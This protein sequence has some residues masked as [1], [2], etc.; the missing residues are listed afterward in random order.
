MPYNYR[1]AFC[2]IYIACAGEVAYTQKLDPIYHKLG[3]VLL[4]VK[5]EWHIGS[6]FHVMSYSPVWNET[7]RNE[8][9]K[10]HSAEIVHLL[11]IVRGTHPTKKGGHFL[12]FKPLLAPSCVATLGFA[13][14]IGFPKLKVL[15]KISVSGGQLKY[16]WERTSKQQSKRRMRE[17]ELKSKKSTFHISL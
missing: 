6:P 14:D 3:H 16:E 13:E 4:V 15:Y 10:F 2:F 5:T 8:T 1:R 17:E 11:L 9:K 7:E 12:H